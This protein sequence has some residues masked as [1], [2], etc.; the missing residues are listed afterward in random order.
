[1]DSGFQQLEDPYVSKGIPVMIGEFGAYTS[2][3]TNATQATWNRDSTF[4]WDKYVAESARVH[5]LS[6][7]YWSTPR[8]SD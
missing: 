1:M 6:P 4:Y 2:G 5:A 7:F 3:L 8:Q